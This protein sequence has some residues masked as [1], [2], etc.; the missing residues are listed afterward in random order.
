M[1]V[2]GVSELYIAMKV[3]HLV[4]LAV[5]IYLLSEMFALQNLP[6]EHFRTF[7]I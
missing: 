3:S 2:F 5:L 7:T 6:K 4:L 1:H